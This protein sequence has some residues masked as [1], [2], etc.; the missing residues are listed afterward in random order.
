MILLIGSTAVLKVGRDNIAKYHNNLI[1]AA[2]F[3]KTADGA[4]TNANGLFSK[5]ALL[6]VPISMNLLTNAI[7]KTVAGPEYDI[8]VNYQKLPKSATVDGFMGALDFGLA[9]MR[10]ILFS[11]FLFPCVALF[12]IQ[13]IQETLTNMKHLQRMNG[14]SA[15]S[16]WGTTYIADLIVYTVMTLLA[17]LAFFVSDILLD[18][19]IYQTKE[20]GEREREKEE[21]E[22]KSQKL[23]H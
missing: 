11:T 4:T 23:N 3:N 15:L 18:V 8:Q 13:P 2:E 7:V 19:R 16:Y 20:I 21:Q 5:S 9:S 22:Y 10:T 6:G 14:V 12:V 1:V 17:L